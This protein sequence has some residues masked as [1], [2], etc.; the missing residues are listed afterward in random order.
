[1]SELPPSGDL[2]PSARRVQEA[3][4]A[5]G[6]AIT[7]REMSETTR[8]AAD[9]AAAC[10]VGVG[11]IVKSLVFL[12][13]ETR[14]PYLLLVCGENRVDEAGVAAH[15][16]ERLTR[17]DGRAVR[18]LTGYAIGGIPPFGHATPLPVAVD[19]RLLG[20]GRVWAAAGAPDACFAIAPGDLV[21][22]SGGRVGD[23]A[24]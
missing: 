10:G 17:P 7:V 21:A 3:A 14:T 2:P 9:A 11:Q 12:G 19:H 22:A 16:G 4:D 24:A 13:A 23:I 15:L 1:M 20:H 5:L 18:E 6:L 8:T